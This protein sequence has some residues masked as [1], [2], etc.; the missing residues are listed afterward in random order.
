VGLGNPRVFKVLPAEEGGP[1]SGIRGL[2]RV[3]DTDKVV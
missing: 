1:K 2:D 3:V